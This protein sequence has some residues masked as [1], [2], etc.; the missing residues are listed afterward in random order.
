V[1]KT[2]K[3]CYFL[4]QQLIFVHFSMKK[5]LTQLLSLLN[6]FFRF[7][8]C[9]LFRAPLCKL[10]LKLSKVCCSIK[11]LVSIPQSTSTRG[12]VWVDKTA[13]RLNG[14]APTIS[15]KF[16]SCNCKLVWNQS[17]WSETL[18][19]PWKTCYLVICNLRMLVIS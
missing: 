5:T 4:Q 16:N 7:L 8:I 2:P 13:N 18:T 12:D 1:I 6:D 19:V 9:L 15:A 3:T 10:L 11:F 14:L 17:T